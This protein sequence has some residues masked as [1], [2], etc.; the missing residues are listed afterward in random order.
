MY[1]YSTD[2]VCEV[3]VACEYFQLILW[4]D[5]VAM[6]ICIR[7]KRQAVPSEASAVAV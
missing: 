1:V 3:H 4:L 7:L 2:V 5:Y 6:K